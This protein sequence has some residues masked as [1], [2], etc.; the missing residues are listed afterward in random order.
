MLLF[1]LYYILIY[2][3]FSWFQHDQSKSHYAYYFRR[4]CWAL[5]L[6][7]LFCFGHKQFINLLCLSKYECMT[8]LRSLFYSRAFLVFEGKALN[9]PGIH[10]NSLI[11]ILWGSY[12][13]IPLLPTPFFT[14]ASI[15]SGLTVHEQV[16]YI[17]FIY[18]TIKHPYLHFWN[19]N[20]WTP[21]NWQLRTSPLGASKLDTAQLLTKPH[22][23]CHLLMW[24]R[25][26]GMQ[27]HAAHSSHEVLEALHWPTRLGSSTVRWHELISLGVSLTDCR[28]QFSNILSVLFVKKQCLSWARLPLP[29]AAYLKLKQGKFGQCEYLRHQPEKVSWI[30]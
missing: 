24:E 25:Q 1:I 2:F 4:A 14:L 29:L 22:C 6:F 13:E 11:F 26:R 10:E 28:L 20:P 3:H 21:F 19:P 7:I 17:H 5:S 30:V 15:S 9:C 16:G 12:L 8:L 27:G 18:I 23:V